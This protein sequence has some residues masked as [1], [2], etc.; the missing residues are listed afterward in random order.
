MATDNFSACTKSSSICC[1]PEPPD[2]NELNPEDMLRFGFLVNQLRKKGHELKKAQELAYN[3]VT[4]E[5]IP[6]EPIG[7]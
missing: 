5:S 1:T 7:G 3:Q 4:C 2:Y 6:F